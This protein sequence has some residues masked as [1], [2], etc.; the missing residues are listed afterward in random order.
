MEGIKFLGTTV[1]S[2]SA[3][4]GWNDCAS[5]FKVTLVES[6]GD[7]FIYPKPGVFVVFQAGDWYFGGMVQNY[8]QRIDTQGNPIFEVVIQDPRD[9]LDGV[10]LILS[11]Y[12]GPVIS[13]VF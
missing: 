4:L 3:N 11:N 2:S 7:Q 12:A 8:S 9:L 13:N 1:V 6:D 10:H 5:S